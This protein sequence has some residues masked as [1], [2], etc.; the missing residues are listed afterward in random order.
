V[1]VILR[2]RSSWSRV[3]SF[4]APLMSRR[5]AQGRPSTST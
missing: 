1:V 5:L 2:I 3:F 4:T